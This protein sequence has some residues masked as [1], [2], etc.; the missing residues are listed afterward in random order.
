MQLTKNALIDLDVFFKSKK[1][2]NIHRPTI[3]FLKTDSSKNTTPIYH[4]GFKE[5]MGYNSSI[6]LSGGVMI[7]EVIEGYPLQSLLFFD[8]QDETS[9][10]D[11]MKYRLEDLEA[12]DFYCINK[13]S[14]D[15]YGDFILQDVK[16]TST[17]MEQTVENPQRRLIAEFICKNM[18]P[19]KIP[20]F[21]NKFKSDN[22]NRHIVRNKKEIIDIK[23][24][25]SSMS[26]NISNEEELR[27]KN[28]L[29]GEQNPLTT[30][31]TMSKAL[32][33][34]FNSFVETVILKKMDQTFLLRI[35]EFIKEFYKIKNEYELKTIKIQSK[36]DFLNFINNGG[37]IHE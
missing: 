22:Y 18:T 32:E 9:L 28:L 26:G 15:P 4:I 5:A 36:L 27:L 23:V 37:K 10:G 6:S 25:I 30:S 35:Q 16:F 17:R 14:E 3:S 12:M 34:V 24:D 33:R 21:Y 19:F 31:I 13:K 8:N 2:S 11:E 1:T 20:Y 7:F 29:L